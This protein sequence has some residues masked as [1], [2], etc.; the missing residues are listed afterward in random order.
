MSFSDVA[1]STEGA[2]PRSNEERVTDCRA[3]RER[4]TI[5][6]DVGYERACLTNTRSRGIE[7][8]APR[9]KR[10][11]R[12]PPFPLSSALVQLNRV[13]VFSRPEQ[14]VWSRWW[15]AN[16]QHDLARVSIRLH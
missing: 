11:N 14:L 2:S 7:T 3:Q 8:H 9:P 4:Q 5:T 15:R 6:T 13:R 10:D 1:T 12:Q 16:E